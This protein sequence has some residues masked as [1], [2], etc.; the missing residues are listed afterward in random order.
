[1]RQNPNSA[2]FNSA[3]L[4]E[5]VRFDIQLAVM[6]RPS[7]DGLTLAF[8]HMGLT[9]DPRAPK[10]VPESVRKALPPDPKIVKWEEE[11]KT[12]FA[13]I[14]SRYGFLNRA[15]GTKM[16]NMYKTLVKMI[17]RTTK[18]RE[19]DLK[20]AYRQQ[21]FYRIHNEE[22]QRQLN[23]VKTNEYEAPVI[24]HQLPERTK[25]Q[26]VICDLSTELNSEEIVR[27]QIRTIN[28]MVALC[29]QREVPQPKP[30]AVA[31]RES[32]SE[33]SSAAD[34]L[35]EDCAFPDAEPIPLELKDK[36]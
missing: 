33:S 32:S 11:R 23:K 25:L 19:E 13:E 20:K 22:L 30:L 36:T 4:N 24:C 26:E 12:L 5:K 28:L 3:Y 9:Y 17:K 34:S 7:T 18:K 16:G 14:R 31:S 35:M 10:D 6:N 8:T 2:V 21:Y 27:R 15:I 29:S 1:M